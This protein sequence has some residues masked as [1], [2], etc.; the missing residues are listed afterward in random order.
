M[1]AADARG[2]VPSDSR[3]DTQ[4]TLN[5]L[6]A[7]L[8]ARGASARPETR[9]PFAEQRLQLPLWPDLERAIPNHLARSSLFAPIASGPRVK[10]FRSAIACRA[11]VRIYFTG[12]QLDMGDCDVFLQALHEGQRS[13]LGE[14]IVI[15]RGPFL[16][17]IGRATGGS[18]YEWLHGAF[19]RLFLGA[20]E[21]EAKRYKIGGSPKSSGMHLVDSF[22]Y[23]PEVDAYF[24]RFDPRIIAMFR[25]REYALIDWEQR[26][27]LRKRVDIAKWLQ[28]YLA[29]HQNGPHRISLRLL[30]AWMGYGSPVRKF[31]QAL[32]EALGELERLEIVAGPRIEQSTRHEPQAVW[33]KL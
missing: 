31:K 19:R 32:L 26:K 7:K 4:R 33:T 29:S 27:R 5:A 16:K 13:V 8:A 2:P 25:N 11:D 20:I 30:K 21:I 10:H 24:L 17:A 18:D 9:L 15:Q 23:D 12:E 3:A 28:N 6:V 1:H 14:R 22:D